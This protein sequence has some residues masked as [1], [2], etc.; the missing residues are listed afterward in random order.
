MRICSLLPGATEVVAALGLADHLVGISHECDYPPGLTAPVMVEPI[1]QSDG[2]SSAEIDRQVRAASAEAHSLYRLREAALAAARPDLIIVQDLCDVCAIT[3]AY[4]DRVVLG[5]TPRPAVLKLHPQ[6]LAECLAD[7]ERIGTAV[8]RKLEARRLIEQLGQQMDEIHRQVNHG[9]ATRPRVACLE[10]LSPLYIAG[11]WVPDMVH[12]AGGIALLSASGAPSQRITWDDLVAARPDTLIIMPCGFTQERA[13]R[14]FQTVA[15]EPHWKTL[16][17][18]VDG[19]VHIVDALSYFSRPGPR[20][21]NGV[22]HLA[23]LLHPSLGPRTSTRESVS[24]TVT[25]RGSF[26]S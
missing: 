15:G 3:P 13:A 17:E 23:S 5:L 4:L 1:I 9:G 11:H 19:R 26:S 6:T 24:S 16:L 12:Q 2:L 20:L 14:E 8:G 25:D 10:W 22:S 7:I 21:V 18:A